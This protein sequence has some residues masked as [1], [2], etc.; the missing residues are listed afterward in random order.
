[1]RSR[2]PGEIAT[3][4]VK[5]GFVYRRVPHLTLKSI[6]NNEEIDAFHA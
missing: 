5:R 4:S 1:L 6:A 3:D 2:G